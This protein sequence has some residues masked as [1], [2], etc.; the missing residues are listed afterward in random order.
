MVC[1][2]KSVGVFVDSS[3]SEVADEFELF[4]SALEK[5]GEG[6]AL[7]CSDMRAAA[8]DRAVAG[9]DSIWRFGI[10]VGGEASGDDAT[11]DGREIPLRVAT[12]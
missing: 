2:L 9:E 11:V 3:T 12:A 8:D 1:L 6:F 5:N 4:V 10:Q 7:R